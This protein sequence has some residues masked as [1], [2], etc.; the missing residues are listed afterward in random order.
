[1]TA[2]S[3]TLR[4]S[5]MLRRLLRSGA[6][7]R[8]MQPGT[9]M[10]TGEDRGDRP[11]HVWTFCYDADHLEEQENVEVAVA[12]GMRHASGVT[13]VLV[14]GVHE[15]TIIEEIGE[16]Y[17]LHRLVQE[18]IA[19]T[20]QRAKLEV[21][22]DYLYLVVPMVTY[23][24]G[25]EA[26]KIEQVSLVLGEDWVLAFLEDPGDVFDAVRNR[27]RA[28]GPLRV[29]RA[30]A[31]MAALVDVIIDGYFVALE[32]LG[33]VM[34]DVEALVLEK[35]QRNTQIALNSLRRELVLLR[36]ALWPVREATMQLERSESGLVRDD[37]RPYLRDSYDHAVQA[38]DIAE[39]LRDLVSGLNDLYLSSLSNRMN[40]VMKTLT[41][42]SSIF[43]PLT[44]IA[45]VYGMNFDP[46]ASP[47]NMPELEWYY[48]YPFSLSLMAG[49]TMGMLWWLRHK[50]W[51]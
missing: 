16:A 36:R 15:A 22:P 2:L 17:G 26:V 10:Y 6:S 19:N 24:S 34:V 40:E 29:R 23:E 49:A 3:G 28:H 46:R 11:V 5:P 44:F 12:C 41:I 8:G 42:V 35:P 1:M 30:D 50:R 32:A 14:D 18:D 9:V 25:A 7:K 51:I 21:Y 4:P 13:W 31:L 45:G 47:Y 43:I 33:D 48:G 38:I 27:L 20:G 37:T 39:S